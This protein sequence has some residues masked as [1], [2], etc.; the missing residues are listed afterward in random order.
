MK[1]NNMNCIWITWEKQPRNKGI[2]DALGCPFYELDIKRGRLIRY[3]LSILMTFKIIKTNKPDI[4]IA[5]NPS[6]VLAFYVIFLRSI[7]KYKVV[8]DAHNAAI[9]PCEGK[10]PILMRLAKWLQKKAN[11]TI[12]T[13]KLVYAVVKNNGGVPVIL[14][15]RL[16]N[17]PILSTNIERD[18][19]KIVFICSYAEDEP[20]KEVIKAAELIPANVYIHITGKYQGKLK[21]EDMPENVVLEGFVPDEKYIELLNSAD[22]IMDLTL[23]EDC[24]VCGAYESVSVNKPMILSDTPAL[25]EYFYL[26][27]IYVQPEVQAI[28]DGINKAIENKSKLD[29]EIVQ[30]KEDINKIWSELFN[31][32]KQQLAKL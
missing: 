26:G 28:V 7:F 22:F 18:K 27:S 1:R 16:P 2:S 20:Y 14:P 17:L 4:V 32:F 13:N 10:K 12:I 30:L 5:Q 6:I 11:L 31:D 25:K 29:T 3:Y 23:R 8:I 21:K 15:D 19:Y 9:Y 24:L